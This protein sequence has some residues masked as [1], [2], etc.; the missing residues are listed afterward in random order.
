[1]TT[2]VARSSAVATPVAESP[3]AGAA[4]ALVPDAEPPAAG[5]IDAALGALYSAMSQ[6]R[7][8]ALQNGQA[9]VNFATRAAQ[10]ALQQQEAAE[11]REKAAQA[12]QGGGFFGSIV[13]IVSDVVDQVAQ[14][15]PDH[16]LTAAGQDASDAVNSPAFWNDLETGALVVAKVAA[17]VGSV[18]AT[19][20][21]GGA[22]GASVA[23]AAI[24]LSVGGEVVSDTHCLGKDSGAVGVAMEA[25]GAVMGG[26]GGIV[27]A[28]STTTNTALAGLGTAASGVSG[29]ANV[30][31]GAAHVK[32]AT[33]AAEAERAAADATEA[34]HQRD[35]MNRLATW[36]V[37]D[38]KADDKSRQQAMQ[39]TQDAIQASDESQAAAVTPATR[40]GSVMT[41]IQQASRTT[42]SVATAEVDD[43]QP[44][45][46]SSSSVL[47]E[48]NS[49]LA[50]SGDP[51][52][53]LAALM[54]NAGAAQRETAQAARQTQEK[55]EEQED[56]AE[57]SAMRQ[58]ANDILSAGWAEG[59]GM[60]FE[61]GM[62]V[63]GAAVDAGAA[64][65]AE[66]AGQR[67]VGAGLN[68]G[69][70]VGNA[71]GLVASAYPKAD[72]AA[73]DANAAA[74]KAASDRARAAGDDLKDASKS[75]DDLVSA[76]LDFYRE[77]TGAKTSELGAALHRS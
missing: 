62:G 54:V 16:A 13:K 31:A 37:D 39:A 44:L 70:K 32:N 58:K 24:L 63:A 67:A 35:T 12:S 71:V 50:L 30:V 64:A 36:V 74:H 73:M 4:A 34:S 40:K 47:P 28:T 76:A 75:G 77:Y 10:Q 11:A 55:V 20:A 8:N 21:T 66:G 23:G 18:S 22:A 51:G 49:L 65:G 41:T 29:G 6:Q 43:E 45:S 33:F 9:R 61:G 17:I 72:E 48:P 25:G 57:V 15:R 46:T 3:G 69:G 5:G 1:M 26:V 53:E 68:A 14:G 52:A 60:A 56:D 7:Q 42:A 59:L 19:V 27:A 38:M 2:A